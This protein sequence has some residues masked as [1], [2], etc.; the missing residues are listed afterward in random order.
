MI[1]TGTHG[2]GDG[3]GTLF[4]R[5]IDLKGEDEADSAWS[6]EIQPDFD[7]AISSMSTPTVADYIYTLRQ[8]VE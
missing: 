7:A 1:A 3:I 4:A 6:R 5:N 8:I 2:S